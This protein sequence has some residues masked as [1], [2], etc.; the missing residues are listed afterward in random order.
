MN[1]WN[2]LIMGAVAVNAPRLI[3][4]FLR[5]DGITIDPALEW[6]LTAFSAAG[7]ALVLTLG[8]LQLAHV[9][10]DTRM[11][12]WRRVVAV[13]A[14]ALLLVLTTIV[15]TPLVV[16][17]TARHDLAEVLSGIALWAWCGLAVVSVEIIIGAAAI[18]R[19]GVAPRVALDETT[20]PVHAPASLPAL[21]TR[22]DD[23][24]S[25]AS[26]R[27][28][29]Y[30]ARDDM[31][32]ADGVHPARNETID[33]ACGVQTTH[34]P[35]DV[36]SAY[37]RACACG[38]EARNAQAYARHARDCEHARREPRTTRAPLRVLRAEGGATG[39]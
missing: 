33:G 5:A 25:W 34:A 26:T 10:G 14:W 23:A 18:V 20:Q 7:T 9:I 36:A 16:M 15:L 21:P 32:A 31:H 12:A 8:N 37:P 29:V 22:A 17:A 6:L 39:D 11:E 24:P 35:S 2:A 27:A 38:Y 30:A 3:I 1:Q 4:G 19:D 28:N 13:V